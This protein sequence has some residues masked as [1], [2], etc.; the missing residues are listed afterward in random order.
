MKTKLLGRISLLTVS[1]CLNNAFGQIDLGNTRQ[2]ESVEFC[3]THKKLEEKKK[4]PDFLQAYNKSQEALRLAEEN[5]LKLGPTRGTIHTIPVVFHVLHNGGVENITDE[6]VYDA[7]YIFNRDFRKRNADTADVFAMFQSRIAD[8]EIE[9]AMA[10]KA[11]DGT[12]FNGITRTVSS[13]TSSGD[14][15]IQIDA[16]ANENNVFK[17]EWPGNQYL[18]I[19]VCADIGGAAGY[20]QTPF[21]WGGWGESMANG[22][23]I[24]HE[25]VG[26]IGSGTLGRSRAL[27]HEV[28]HWLNLEH[29]WGPNNN[30]GNLS[31]CSTD[32]GVTDTPNTIGVTQCSL[33]EATCGPTA[34]VENYMDYSYCSKM[35]TTGQKTRM[36]AALGSSQG[37][38][39]NIVTTTNLDLTGSD[40]IVAVN[41][42]ASKT[43]L[44]TTGE[45]QFFDKSYNHIVTRN[46]TFA[47]STVAQSS[48]IDPI[49]QYNFPGVYPVILT[50]SDGVSTKTLT[51]YIRVYANPRAMPIL[52]GFELYQQLGNTIE[53][54]VL[55][56]Q[57]NSTFELISGTA[58][59][60]NKSIKIDNYSVT[61]SNLDELISATYDLSA[62]NASSPVTL[63]F[64][65]SYRKKLSTNNEKLAVLGSSNC[66]ST[67]GNLKTLSG[68]AL[69]SIVVTEPWTP[70]SASDWTQIHVTNITASYWN[71]N[72]RFKFRFEGNGGNNLYLDDINIYNSA[73][74]SV[75]VGTE[76]PPSVSLEEIELQG[77][78]SIYP[79]PADDELQVSYEALHSGLTKISVLDVLGQQLI[80]ENIQSS[81]GN[82]LVLIPTEKLST[83]IYVVKIVVNGKTYTENLMIK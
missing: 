41:F 59:T 43:S 67:Y 48:E 80:V 74:S 64:K 50:V 81:Q 30:P 61:G 7:F 37:G 79:N 65:Y 6:Q 54:E 55:N 51:K 68:N 75:L 3:I 57:N 22:I 11:P 12:T 62:V 70:L 82:N 28:G 19:F 56:Q 5:L 21:S 8:T 45:V 40:F 9:F 58:S 13:A 14:G 18:N 77:G 60:G 69:S 52:D 63:S 33:N 31:S 17:G 47:G 49:V 32:D 29:T 34:N 83:G 44:C 66:G 24:L 72:F 35:F 76:V 16:I 71:E 46:W 73:P 20:T 38:R 26:A 1:L 53:W 39:D 36:K 15:Q 42:D 25:Y 23:Y 10:T 78:V 27:T 2:G 4:N